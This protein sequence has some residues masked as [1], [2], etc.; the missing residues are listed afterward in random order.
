MT[1]SKKT[2]FAIFLVLAFAI[3]SVFAAG[4]VLPNKVANAETTTSN[5]HDNHDGW[6]E[7]TQESFT[8]GNYASGNLAGGEKMT[9]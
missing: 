1:Q 8:S 4:L 2:I 7:L 9:L 6:R 5:T 3:C